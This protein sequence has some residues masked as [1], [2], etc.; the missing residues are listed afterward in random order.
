MKIGVYGGSFN[1]IHIG[2]L[3]VADEV[4]KRLSL[5]KVIFI[6]AGYPYFK[7]PSDVLNY[8][9]RKLMVEKSI[10]NILYFECS[11]I[12]SSETEPS[13]TAV[14]LTKLKEFY[15]NDELFLIVGEDTLNVMNKWYKPEL[16]PQLATI[17]AL[18]RKSVKTSPILGQYD[19][20]NVEFQAI[21]LPLEISISSSYVREQI[22]SKGSYKFLV[23][24][25]AYK[26]IKKNKL[27]KQKNQ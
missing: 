19:D 13:Y 9:T 7:N 15:K 3:T 5:D 20:H 25:E 23:P 26:I 6:P 4:K 16:I 12:E 18:S 1:P 11:D 10:K 17:V 21:Y 24:K 22:R 14:T 8:K 2:H 27:Y